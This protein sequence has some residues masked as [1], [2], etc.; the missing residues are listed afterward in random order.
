MAHD[1]ALL[2]EDMRGAVLNG[3]FNRLKLLLPE[4]EQAERQVANEDLADLQAVKAQAERTGACLQGAL[5]G[6]KSA[7]R[8]VSEIAE[9]AKGLTT[10]DRV[11]AKAMLPVAAPNSRRV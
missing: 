3:N 7:R 9:A 6:V 8:R 1:V 10:Y 4:L 5:Q 11:G 2:L